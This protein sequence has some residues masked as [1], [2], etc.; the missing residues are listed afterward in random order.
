M[1]SKQRERAERLVRDE[2][3]A[4]VIRIVRKMVPRAKQSAID[5]AARKFSATPIPLLDSEV[6]ACATMSDDEI[7]TRWRSTYESDVTAT[8]ATSGQMP[9]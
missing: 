9:S 3:T 5:A 8:L 1:K 6:E 2:T 4:M 7:R